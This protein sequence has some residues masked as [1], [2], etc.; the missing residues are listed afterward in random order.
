M[1]LAVLYYEGAAAAD[2]TN[3]FFVPKTPDRA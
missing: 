3:I 1:A 2:A